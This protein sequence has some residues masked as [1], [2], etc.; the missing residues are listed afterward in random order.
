MAF[1]IQSRG[2]RRYLGNENTTEVHDLQNE[3][4]QC[5]IDEIL[6]ANHAAGFD[7]DTLAQAHKEGYD[8]GHYCIGGSTR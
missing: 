3:K 8:N 7:P 6:A 1:R 5:Q 2:S 4:T